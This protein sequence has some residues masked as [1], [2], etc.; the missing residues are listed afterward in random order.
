MNKLKQKLSRHLI[1]L[2]LLLGTSPLH[3]LSF[4]YAQPFALNPVNEGIQLGLGTALSGSAIVFDKI[5]KIKKNNYDPAEYDKKDIPDL[6]ML[7]A[8]PY[9]KGLHITGT[10]TC[11]L[12]LMTPAL[13]GILPSNEWLTIG[14]MY[15]ETLLFANGIKEW[16]KLTVYRARPYMYFDNY[17]Q[18]KVDDGDWNCSFPS[19][20][21]TLAF[22]G[23]AFTTMV[24]C[25]C[26]PDSKWK[27]AVAGTSFG[28]ATLTGAL[29]MASGN[30]FFSD[31]FA[32]ALIGTICGIAVP[33]MH[34]KDFYSKFEVNR[35]GSTELSFTP[36]GINLAF[37]F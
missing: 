9:S 37:S 18:K 29:R 16:I 21:T 20:H 25:Q 19:G 23:A 33:Y 5:V 32:G 31:V 22:S 28:I 8:R 2:C 27:Y 30:H 10:V 17:P 26:F 15:A 4:N 24:F 11:G 14:V 34:T 12:A 3:S 6:D 36:A 13:F 35:H 1:V 7:F